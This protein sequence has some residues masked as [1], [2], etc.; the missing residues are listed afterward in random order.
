MATSWSDTTRTGL[1]FWTVCDTT[2]PSI[3]CA[4]GPWSSGREERHAQ[5]SMPWVAPEPRT[6]PWSIARRSVPRRPP[7]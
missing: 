4:D 7:R 1:D 5:W 2:P 6:W 3:L